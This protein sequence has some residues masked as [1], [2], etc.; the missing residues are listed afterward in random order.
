MV[1]GWPVDT[2][3][4]GLTVSQPVIA[5]RFHIPGVDGVLKQHRVMVVAVL[6]GL[7]L[8]SRIQVL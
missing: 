3:A 6:A 2:S 8:S 4:K 1:N 7:F 5:Q